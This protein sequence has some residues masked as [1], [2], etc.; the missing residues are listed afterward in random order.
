MKKRALITIAG[1]G[2]I[3]YFVSTWQSQ[4]YM[5]A[6]AP[7]QASPKAA[8]APVANDPPLGFS[9]MQAP[10]KLTI[11]S[12]NIVSTILPVGREAN[13]EM[14][15]PDSLTDSGWYK[16]GIA[17]GNPGKSVIAAHTGYP[18][19]P[20]Q[21]RKLEQLQPKDTFSVTDIAG[22]VAEFEIIQK[23]AYRPEEAPLTSIFGDSPTPR[24]ALITCAGE[25]QPASESYTHRLVIFAVRH[26]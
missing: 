8:L 11:P 19:N 17:P 22:N 13:N 6:A 7:Q 24:L 5:S 20:S 14:S 9:V 25:W 21:F 18:D 23:A 26:K 10:Q 12:L 3:L 16:D 2:A 4:P 15:L 1:M